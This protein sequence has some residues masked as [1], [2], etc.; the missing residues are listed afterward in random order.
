[1]TGWD[2]FSASDL[3]AIA[4][5]IREG[6]LAPQPSAMALHGYCEPERAQWLAKALGAMQA[7]AST[8]AELLELVAQERA[9]V[10]AARGSIDVVW[11]GPEVAGMHNRETGAVMRELF[12]SAKQSVLAVGYAIH[13]G[14]E[15]LAPLAA[16]MDRHPDLEVRMV[17]DI[18]RA[19]G[20]TTCE[21]DLVARYA[22]EF[23]REQWPGAT[24]PAVFYDPRSL[25]VEMEQRSSMHAKCVVV[26]RSVALVTSANFTAAAQQRNFELGLLVRDADLAGTV[27]DHFDALVRAGVL[28]SL[29]FGG[30]QSS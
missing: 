21:H 23:R 15:V 3:Q 20:D 16:S 11:T 14:Q 4:G 19:F 8:L 27:W 18:Q 25:A 12:S 5:A 26:D 17:V 9:R 1:M 24:L 10:A 13:Q 28:R 2:R 22:A 30:G 29:T 7:S 6:R